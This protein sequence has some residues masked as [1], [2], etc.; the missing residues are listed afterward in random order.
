MLLVVVM[1]VAA[2]VTCSS[3]NL[4][5]SKDQ[6]ACLFCLAVDYCNADSGSNWDGLLYID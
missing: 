1:L 6:T 3:N 2:G 4:S 5:L